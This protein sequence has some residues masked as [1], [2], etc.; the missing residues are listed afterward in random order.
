MAGLSSDA[1]RG[2]DALVAANKGEWSLPTF[3]TDAT[4]E[5]MWPLHA[6]VCG[7]LGGGNVG[8]VWTEDIT[9]N[10]LRKLTDVLGD[11]DAP[12]VAQS[13]IHWPLGSSHA[14]VRGQPQYMLTASQVIL[15]F[16]RGGKIKDSSRVALMASFTKA[17]S[18][19]SFTKVTPLAWVNLYSMDGKTPRRRKATFIDKLVDKLHESGEEDMLSRL[20]SR[21]M[22]GAASTSGIGDMPYCELFEEAHSTHNKTLRANEMTTRQDAIWRVIVGCALGAS[23]AA[24]GGDGDSTS[25]LTLDS[26]EAALGF[27][28]DASRYNKHAASIIEH[29]LLRH[30][31]YLHA[32]WDSKESRTLLLRY[33][34]Q[35]IAP[36]FFAERAEAT[37]EVKEMGQLT[38]VALHQFVRPALQ[39]VAKALHILPDGM[40]LLDDSTT[41]RQQWSERARE[42]HLIGSGYKDPATGHVSVSFDVEQ[43]VQEAAAWPRAQLCTPRLDGKGPGYRF[44]AMLDTVDYNKTGVHKHRTSVFLQMTSNRVLAS[45]LCDAHLLMY[46]T[47]PDKKASILAPHL[48]DTLDGIERLRNGKLPCPSTGELLPVWSVRW[49][50]DGAA[51]CMAGEKGSPASDT[52]LPTSGATMSEVHDLDVYIPITWH[53]ETVHLQEKAAEALKAT[54]SIAAT[55]E[56]IK[57]FGGVTGP[58]L[59]RRPNDESRRCS[60]HIISTPGNGLSASSSTNLDT[61]KG[62]LDCAAKHDIDEGISKEAHVTNTR[63]M[64]NV[65]LYGTATGDSVRRLLTL[66]DGRYR[67]LAAKLASH[68]ERWS[69]MDRQA[70]ARESKLLEMETKR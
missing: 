9:K 12:L 30:T 58:S 61:A 59:L 10:P 49:A 6:I 2:V 22:G 39:R 35:K 38:D 69:K 64:G 68:G 3:T 36:T 5:P 13:V 16:A 52:P 57:S 21:M 27:D 67:R 55:R 70:A 34:W 41:S 4:D 44:R 7:P 26:L 11:E 65:I 48:K 62:L 42:S 28:L 53:K 60:L 25:T 31:G 63:E 56:L 43:V 24:E 1:A 51:W 54:S 66:G 17:T 50:L 40:H 23:L 37:W 15:F 47:A 29:L 14:V 18:P 46:T 19:R 33:H 8:A 20:R 32:L 45:S